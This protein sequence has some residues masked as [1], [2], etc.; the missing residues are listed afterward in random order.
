MD[1][2]WKYL[3]LSSR[4]E[5]LTAIETVTS[6]MKGFAIANTLWGLGKCSVNWKKDIPSRLK[7]KL[8]GRVEVLSPLNPHSVSSIL[9]GLSRMDVDW[10]SL[11]V[12]TKEALEN[13]L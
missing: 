11:P 9:S 7:L 8:L 6:R 3:A 1:A 5:L 2:N 10:D 4:K 13:S 12:V